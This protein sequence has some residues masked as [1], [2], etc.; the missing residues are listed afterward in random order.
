M[1]RCWSQITEPEWELDLSILD[2]ESDEGPYDGTAIL[3]VPIEVVRAL[4]LEAI[5]D[6]PITFELIITEPITSKPLAKSEPTPS[7]AIA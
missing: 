1:L 5:S 4:V 6:K 3:D 7:D 2:E